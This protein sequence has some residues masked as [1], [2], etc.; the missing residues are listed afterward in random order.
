MA[1]VELVRLHHRLP[2]VHRALRIDR[3]TGDDGLARLLVDDPGDPFFEGFSDRVLGP[4]PV[5]SAPA[6]PSPPPPLEPAAVPEVSATPPPASGIE[7][8]R[9]RVKRR[10]RAFLLPAAAL[11]SS[12]RPR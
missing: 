7:R 2:R 3:G 12:S 4:K 5:E 11:W 10:D 8:A 9:P 6:A 1:S